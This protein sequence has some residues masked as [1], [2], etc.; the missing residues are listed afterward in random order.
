MNENEISFLIRGCVFKIYNNLGPGLLE[1]AYEAALAYE[2]K[3]AGLSV[4]SQVGLPMV[5]ETIKVD[6]GYRMD[7]VVEG[8]SL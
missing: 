4:N 7:L 6:V 8:K 1:S 3:L 5:Y 2:L